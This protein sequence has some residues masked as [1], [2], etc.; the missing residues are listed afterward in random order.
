MR[1]GLP[2]PFDQLSV[3]TGQGLGEQVGC[4]GEPAVGGGDRDRGRHY[5]AERPCRR[6]V[7]GLPVATTRL[8]RRPSTLE[9]RQ[10][11]DGATSAD[12]RL[13]TEPPALLLAWTV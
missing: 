8:A 2:G 13:A 6:E 3:A 9:L 5:E 10:A 4:A 1:Q 11:G 7:Q 12:L